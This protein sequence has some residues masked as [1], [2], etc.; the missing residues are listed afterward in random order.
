MKQ[1]FIV[2]NI[3]GLHFRPASHIV[4]LCMDTTCRVVLYH[5]DKA[6]NPRSMISILKLGARCGESITVVAEGNEAQEVVG[7]IGH[8]IEST[9]E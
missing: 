9:D 5:G 1:T 4:N 6:A 7:A 2:G 3:E 8:I